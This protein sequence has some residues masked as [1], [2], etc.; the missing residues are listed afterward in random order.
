LLLTIA[1]AWA[2]FDIGVGLAQTPSFPGKVGVNVGD[3]RALLLADAAKTFRQWRQFDG[4]AAAPTDAQGWPTTDAW[5]VLFDYRPTNAWNF[6]AQPIDDPERYQANVFGVYLLSFNGSADLSVSGQAEVRNLTYDKAANLTRAELNVVRTEITALNNASGLVVL[7][8]RNTRRTPGSALNTGITNLRALRPGLPRDNAGVISAPLLAALRP[9]SFL[10]AMD[11]IETNHRIFYGSGDWIE[12]ADRRRPEDASQSLQ[13]GQAFG[14][15]WEY[16][17]LTAN[18]SN[19]DLWLNVPAEATDDYIEQLARFVRDRLNPELKVYVEYSN[20]VWNFGFGQYA[21]NKAAARD[22]VCTNYQTPYTTEP[23]CTQISAN[24]NLNQPDVSANTGSGRNGREEIW[25]RRR[26]ARRTKEIGDKFRLV[27]EA[28]RAGDGQRI[29]PVLAWWA[30]QPQE[31][32]EML[33]WLKS[34]FGDPDQYLYGIATTTYLGLSRATFENQNATVEDILAAMESSMNNSA[35]TRQRTIEVARAFRLKPLVYEGGPATGDV[36]AQFVYETNIA[37]RIRAERTTRVAEL[38]T[39]SMNELWFGLGGDAYAHFSLVGAYSRYGCWGLTDDITNVNRNHKYA[40]VAAFSGKLP[41]LPP[42]ELRAESGQGQV[43]LSWTASAEATGYVVR[44]GESAWGPFTI[45]NANVTETS[46]TDTSVTNGTTYFYVVAARNDAQVTSHGDGVS[47]NPPLAVT[48]ARSFSTSTSVSA[49]SYQRM[50]LAPDSIA[51]AFGVNLATTTQG[52]TALPLPTMLGGTTVR[53]RDSL[54]D[55]LL[56]P[57]FFVSPQQINYLL[58]VGTA[59]GAVTI[60]IISGDGA[61]AT[62]SLTTAPT[63]P[64]LF[65]ANA[66]GAGVAAA[67]VYRQR[68]DGSESYEPVARFDMA[69]NRAVPV[70]IDLGPETDRVFLLL[71]GTGLRHHNGTVSAQLGGQA[72]EILYAGAQPQYVGLDQIN[73]RLSRTLIGSGT[74][75][76]TLTVDGRNTNSLT[77][78]F[79]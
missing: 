66:N 46:F 57:L 5:T 43:R 49:A 12:W 7:N 15:A 45:V 70:P 20:E 63:A 41:P 34:T 26:H 74:V 55:E 28:G 23:A 56:A 65:S 16:V 40:A 33:N 42:T 39:R 24:S 54:G 58:P 21:W 48:P 52:A 67:V 29:R 37:N 17:I 14:Y 35:T 68:A 38:I 36:N 31:Y 61:V 32:E 62:E 51:S 50:A 9:F 64:S 6:P 78:Q 73:L 59:P 3:A 10:R 11:L 19:R 2:T 47:T 18:L 8:F 75:Q 72:A 60:T 69:Q 71:F 77:L 53:V 79:K 25:A 76:L 22:E 30:I 4:N 44:R 27:F 1:L 13:T